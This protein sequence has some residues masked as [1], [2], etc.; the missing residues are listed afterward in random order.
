MKGFVAP[1]DHG[2]Y[3]FLRR[4]PELEEVNF[5]RPGA[6]PFAALQPGEFF[7]FKLK[8]PQNAIGGFGQFARFARLPVW[9]AWD[10]F[11]AA[12]GASDVY[13]LMARLERLGPRPDIPARLD[14][15][16]GCVAIAFPVFF[17]PDEWVTV[18]SDWSRNIVSGRN[19]D[20]SIG[21]GPSAVAGML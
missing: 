13:E 5:W 15:V 7:F 1:T 12:N 11:G 19:Y 17:P 3:E 18:P 20:L 6:G 4:R 16:V 21:E 14:R 9:Q 2:W 8:A 10:L